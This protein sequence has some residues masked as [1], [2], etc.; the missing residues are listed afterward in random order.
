[1]VFLGVHFMLSFIFDLIAE[2]EREIGTLYI[3]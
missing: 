3:V 1:M 2:T